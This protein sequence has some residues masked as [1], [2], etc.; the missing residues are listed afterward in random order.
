M[1]N[2]SVTVETVEVTVEVVSPAIEVLA[3]NPAVETVQVGLQGPPGP[4]GPP[5]SP[6]PPV[7]LS[8]DPYNVLRFDQEGKLFCPAVQSGL[9]DW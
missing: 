9:T 7:E 4:P 3:E 5:G 1:A 2:Q 6:G 8:L